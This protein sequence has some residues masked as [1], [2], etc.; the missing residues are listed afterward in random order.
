MQFTRSKKYDFPPE[1]TI[2]G[3]DVLDV[4]KEHTI[5][6]V[7]VQSDLKWQ[8]H[9]QEMVRRATSTTCRAAERWERWERVPSQF[10]ILAAILA[11]D[12]RTFV[13]K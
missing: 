4:K 3:S 10:E 8:S 13:A 6:G 2:G 1:F 9:C 12:L 11:D 7:V 5:L